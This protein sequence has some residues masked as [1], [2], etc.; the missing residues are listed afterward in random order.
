MSRWKI[1]PGTRP[2]EC[3]WRSRVVVACAEMGRQ[4]AEGQQYVRIARVLRMLDPEG[5]LAVVKPPDPRA[6][7][8]FGTLPVTPPE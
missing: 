6:D 1:W 4:G 3:E 5:R 7:P 8:L 2:H